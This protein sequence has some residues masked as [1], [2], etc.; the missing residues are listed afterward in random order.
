MK[1]RSKVLCLVLVMGLLLCSVP[2]VSAEIIILDPEESTTVSLKYTDVCAVQGQIIFSNPSIISNIQ[3]DLS[4]SNMEG[5]VENG[6]IFLYSNDPKGASGRIDIIVTIHSGAVKGAS[7]NVTFQY[8]TAAPNST[9][10]GEVQTVT[11]TVT[12]STAGAEPPTTTAP[13]TKPSG[14]PTYTDTT[15]L[16]K[17]ISIAENL[18][19]YDYTKQ[20][21]TVV[22]SALANARNHLDSRSQADVDKAATRLKD[23]LTKL[24]KVDYSALIA[25]M[26]K[27]ADMAQHE[28]LPEIWDRFVKA[29]QN[30]RVQRTSG[31]Q[32]AVN[33]ATKELL[34][35]KEE[36]MK[37][38]EE[39]GKVVEVEKPVEVPTEPDHPYCNNISHTVFLIIMI[40]S[41]ALNAVLITLIVMYFV[42]KHKNRQD[43]T[44]LV[45]YDIEEDAIS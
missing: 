1:I 9:V 19:Y 35:S 27:A 15:A 17:Q 29:L 2:I 16:R 11:T 6:N 28:D 13:T 25:A 23:A 5:L 22:S 8:A 40:A 4:N 45:D 10:L 32:A 41:L 14:G 24:V 38:L 26:D 12:V 34:A 33:A 20:T 21:W 31:D 39:L 44:P 18:T 36:L 37:A 30:A 42:K 7:C 43:N 3:Y